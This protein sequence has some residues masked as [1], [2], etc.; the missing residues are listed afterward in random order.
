MSKI[1][2][3]GST[4][5]IGKRLVYQLLEQGHEI[6]ALTRIKGTGLKIPSTN[7][8]FHLIYGDFRDP[9]SLDPFPQDIDAVY[10]LVHS[11]GSVVQNL[12]DEEEKTARH[13]ISAIEKTNC[14]QIIFLGGI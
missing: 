11:M 14:K 6:Y 13:F 10:Y 2:I 12:V 5:F 1:I 3:T 4:G 7:P 9:N 8:H